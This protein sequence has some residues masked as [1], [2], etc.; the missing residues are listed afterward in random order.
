MDQQ[1]LD[2]VDA[3]ALHAHDCHP[4]E[5]DATGLISR[6]RV[7]SRRP[8]MTGNATLTPTVSFIYSYKKISK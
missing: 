6:T 7:G 8:L 1:D 3:G 5:K 4:R 2:R